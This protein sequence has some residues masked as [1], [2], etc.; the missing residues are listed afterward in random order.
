MIYKFSGFVVAIY[1]RK[2]VVVETKVAP[3]GTIAVVR[4]TVCRDVEFRRIVMWPFIGHKL[5]I[6]NWF[7]L[8]QKQGP[9]VKAAFLKLL[10]PNTIDQLDS[11]VK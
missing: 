10:R 3:V 9:R 4:S 2:T 8:T 7:T 6:Q 11:R 5:N 1:M